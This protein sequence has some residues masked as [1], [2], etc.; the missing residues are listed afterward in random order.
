MCTRRGHSFQVSHYETGGWYALQSSPR[1][2]FWW[3]Y[4]HSKK[5]HY[6]LTKNCEMNPLCTQLSCYQIIKW[7]LLLTSS[8]NTALRGITMV[9]QMSP[10]VFWSWCVRKPHCVKCPQD[11][12]LL[13]LCLCF[14]FSCAKCFPTALLQRLV[15]QVLLGSLKVN[16]RFIEPRTNHSCRQCYLPSIFYCPH[17]KYCHEFG[18]CKEYVF[19]AM[20]YDL[21]IQIPLMPL[22]V[23]M[24]IS[25]YFWRE[26][27]LII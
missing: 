25:T 23:M 17:N 3:G 16:N 7:V 20:H 9:V 12:V 1:L 13:Q 19:K 5:V 8:R 18:V 22:G 11:N 15:L 14:F 4:M 2:R 10:W 24:L 6:H 21:A 27:Q 26:V